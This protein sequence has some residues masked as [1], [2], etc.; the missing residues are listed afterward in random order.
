MQTLVS[1]MSKM[2][3]QLHDYQS[4]SIR[5]EK[6]Q[7]TILC[8]YILKFS[9]FIEYNEKL[10]RLNDCPQLHQNYMAEKLEIIPFA[11]KLR[12]LLL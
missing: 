3:Q 11:Y 9:T 2:F 10:D 5:I 12:N 6:F 7:S 4:Y 1:G 8:V